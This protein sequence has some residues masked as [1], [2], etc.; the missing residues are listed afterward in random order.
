MVCNTASAV[1]SRHSTGPK[2]RART[3]VCQQT[4]TMSHNFG[5]RA[6]RRGA[7]HQGLVHGNVVRRG[8]RRGQQ[9]VQQQDVAPELRQGVFR[10]GLAGRLLRRLA[11]FSANLRTNIMHR[12]FEENLQRGEKPQRQS[13]F[14]DAI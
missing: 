11:R 5:A 2:T 9:R 3:H 13:L 14:C 6:S 7:L 1:C 4:N 12:P 10:A 8:R